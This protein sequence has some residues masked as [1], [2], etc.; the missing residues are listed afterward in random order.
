MGPLTMQSCSKEKRLRVL[1]KFL[2]PTNDPL[3]KNKS[4]GKPEVEQ[5]F[6][7]QAYG[8]FII[9]SQNHYCLRSEDCQVD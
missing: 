2:H 5:N 3:F 9:S 6:I 4:K 7:I 8:G 1:E